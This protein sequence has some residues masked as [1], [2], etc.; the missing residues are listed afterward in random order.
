MEALTACAVAAATL[1]KVLI[2]ED[3]EVSIE[4]LTLWHKSGGRSGDWIR[5]RTGRALDPEPP[6]SRF[7]WTVKPIGP[8]SGTTALTGS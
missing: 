7:R 2:G 6:R 8:V 4:D 1:V 3:P 5:K